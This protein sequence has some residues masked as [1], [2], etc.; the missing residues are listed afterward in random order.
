MIIWET[1][2][3]NGEYA[4]DAQ[5]SLHYVQ[6]LQN[7]EYCLIQ[8][9]FKI[10]TPQIVEDATKELLNIEIIEQYQPQRVNEVQMNSSLSDVD[11]NQFQSQI[12][13][14]EEPEL[15]NK[16]DYLQLLELVT[17]NTGI[18][19][20]S[21]IH[22]YQLPLLEPDNIYFKETAE[23]KNIILQS[24]WEILEN[25]GL[26]F[27]NKKKL[28]IQKEVITFMLR[29]LGSNLLMG[30]SLISISL[31]VNIFEKRSN[32]ERA[33]YSLGYIWLLEKAGELQDPLEQMKLVAQFSL[34]YNIMFLNMEKP[35]NPILGVIFQ[36]TMN[37]NLLYC[38]QIS[39]HPPVLGLYILGRNFKLTGHLESQAIFSAN[40]IT[41]Q[42]YVYLQVTFTNKTTIIFNVMPR[43]IQGMTIGHRQFYY[44]GFGWLV[45]LENK[46]FCD[47][48]VTAFPGMFSKKV[49]P[50]DYMEGYFI[51]GQVKE[52]IYF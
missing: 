19:F 31:P 47:I 42:N 14:E 7:L 46:L 32:L 34:A 4:N 13:L 36:G 51:K 24:D 38:E 15:I 27:I 23:N 29:K 21:A 10:P 3:K 49:T 16:N 26:R 40:S 9:Y 2:T 8:K 39:H 43:V 11:C 33:C 1:E 17:K 48:V 25:G 50:Q 18:I 45:D 35:Y 37:G 30:K 44:N 41:G 5:L 6:E 12:V 20:W 28:E 52:V 22:Y